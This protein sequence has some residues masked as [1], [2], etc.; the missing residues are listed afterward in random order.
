LVEKPKRPRE[1][2]RLVNDAGIPEAPA[3]RRTRRV[4]GVLGLALGGI[5]LARKR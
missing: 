5:G 4:L 2:S 1:N 3:A